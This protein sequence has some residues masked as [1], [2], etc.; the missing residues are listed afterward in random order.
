M[1]A[2]NERDPGSVV[3]VHGVVTPHAATLVIHDGK[4]GAIASVVL[5]VDDLIDLLTQCEDKLRDEVRYFREMLNRK[6]TLSQICL[7]ALSAER[8]PDPPL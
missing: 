5:D 3:G 8:L 7:D 6:E 2:R 4:V 1:H